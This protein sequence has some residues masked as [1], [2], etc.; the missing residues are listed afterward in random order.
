MTKQDCEIVDLVIVGAIINDPLMIRQAIDSCPEY[1]YNGKY[2]LFDGLSKNR[3]FDESLQYEQYKEDIKTI[4]SDFEVIEFKECIYFREMIELF[5]KNSVSHKL[6]VVQDDVVLPHFDLKSVVDL[7]NGLPDCKILC[8]PHKIVDKNYHWY[9]II[10]SQ[11]SIKKT[12]GFTE[13][14]FLCDRKNILMICETMPKNNKNNKRFIEFIYHTMMR[15][16]KW[17]KMSEQQKLEYWSQFG[18][19]LTNDIIHKHLVGKRR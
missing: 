9:E 19:Y 4:Y 11:D 12:H 8:F 3:T 1:N 16:K 5:A 15:S 7:M 2:I 18:S 10:E 14:C 17:Q 13:R 6:F